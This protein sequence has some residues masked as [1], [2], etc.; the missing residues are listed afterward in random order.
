MFRLFGVIREHLHP[1]DGYPHATYINLFNPFDRVAEDCETMDPLAGQ[2]VNERLSQPASLFYPTSYKAILDV[3][4]QL[5][6]QGVNIDHLCSLGEQPRPTSVVIW[7]VS[8][9]RGLTCNL[10]VHF[11]SPLTYYIP[12]KSGSLS[13][14]GWDRGLSRCGRPWHRSDIA[15]GLHWERRMLC[16]P[17]G[18]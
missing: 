8:I 17:Y 13:C 6:L 7:N 12:A 14:Q 18:A 3:Q 15:I 11:V 5:D 16:A 4:L 1:T 9:G 10:Y 2:N